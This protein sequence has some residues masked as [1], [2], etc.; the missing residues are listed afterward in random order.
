LLQEA[1]LTND[2]AR[3]VELYK[4]FQTLFAEDV[5]SLMLYQP[6]YNYAVDSGVHSVQVGPLTRA[7]DRF[8]TVCSWTMAT[9]RMLYSEAREK[10]LVGQPLQ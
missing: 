1:R 7:S 9:Q 6:V 8:R 3:R 10:G 5:P 2:Q 4:R